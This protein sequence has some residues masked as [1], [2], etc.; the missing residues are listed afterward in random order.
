MYKSRSHQ[1][2]QKTNT[3]AYLPPNGNTH[4]ML[5]WLPLKLY[6]ASR[7]FQ[8]GTVRMASGMGSRSSNG[9]SGDLGSCNGGIVGGVVRTRF[10]EGNCF[11]EGSN[12]FQ[13]WRQAG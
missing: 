3:R 8:D 10:F 13:E 7:G 6:A 12:A 1:P 2:D 5:V 11:G 9:G 4:A